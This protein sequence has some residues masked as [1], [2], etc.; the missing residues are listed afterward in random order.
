MIWRASVIGLL[1][2]ACSSASVAQ[3]DANSD[4]PRRDATPDGPGDDATDGAAAYSHTI[5][6]D[7]SDDFT[8]N[9]TFGT[10]SAA[11]G[12]RVSWDAETIYLGYGGPDLDPAA[13]QTATKW[14]FAYLDVDPGAATGATLSQTYRTQHATF[15]AGF[16][17]EYYVRWKCDGSLVSLEQH[18]AGGTWTTA[19]VPASGR[20]GTFLELAIPR[21]TLGGATSLGIVTW[22]INEADGLEASYGGLYPGNFA[23]GYAMNLVLTKYVKADLT[24][25]RVPN[26]PV[27][28]SP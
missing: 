13:P 14:L 11:Y 10:T 18:Q 6:I 28:Q 27:N 16:G 23:D 5:A 20:A 2:T 4:G 17:A 1:A 26:D 7:G 15:P 3:L 22:M 21:A 9:E 8:A 25:S 19:S 24:A 12:A